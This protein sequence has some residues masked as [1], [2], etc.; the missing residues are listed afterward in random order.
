MLNEPATQFARNA[1]L[2]CA[3]SICWLLAG[4]AN[5]Q[6]QQN[7]PAPPPPP[8]G[9]VSELSTVDTPAT[10]RSRVNLVVVPVVVRDRQGHA[11]GTLKKEDFQLFDK[12]KPQ[13]ITRFSVEK[14][15]DRVAASAI[16]VPATPEEPGAPKA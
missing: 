3:F 16:A 9:N 14:Q 4:R 13:T 8:A 7:P 10:F 15:G 6:A 2:L 1:R 11:I 5:G 12:G